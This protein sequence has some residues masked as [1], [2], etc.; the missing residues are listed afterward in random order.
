MEM[1]REQVAQVIENL[2]NK[3]GGNWEWDD[4]CYERF[5]DR[6]L[7]TIQLLSSICGTCFRQRRRVN[8]AVRRVGR[9]WNGLCVDC[10]MRDTDVVQ[11]ALK[12]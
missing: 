8:I 3:S 9:F 7:R 5:D 6:E 10:V 2:L 1:N 12:N 4:Y 11:P